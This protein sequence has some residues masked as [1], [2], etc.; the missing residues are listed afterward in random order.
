M[1]INGDTSEDE[2]TIDIETVEEEEG[3]MEAE[4]EVFAEEEPMNSPKYI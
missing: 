3:V 2:K 4:N 1:E